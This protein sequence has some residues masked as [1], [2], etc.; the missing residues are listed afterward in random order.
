MLNIMN[1]TTGFEDYLFDVLLTTSKN[2]PSLEQTLLDCQP[3]QVYKP[4]TISAYSNYA[5][6]LAAYI[7]EQIIGQD[8]YE[9]LMES[10]FLP[11]N[12]NRTSAHPLLSDKLELLDTKAYGY[13]PQK[14]AGFTLGSWSYVPLYPAGSVNGTAE[15]LA[16]FAIALMPEAGQDSL[17]FNKRETLDEMLTQSHQMGPQLHGFAHGFMEW[18]GEYRGVGHGGNS[19]AFST[20]LNIVP[21]E[22]FGVIVLTNASNEMDISAGLTEALIGR[23][24]KSV[25][26]GVGDL[27]SAKEVEGTYI[28]ARRMHRGFL[29]L[30][31][32]LSLLKVKVL[33]PNKIQLSMAGQVSTLVQTSPYVFERVDADGAI[34]KYHFGTVYF[35]MSDGKVMRMSGDYLPLPS[36]R[37]E[38]WLAVSLLVVILSTLYFLVTPI[39]LLIG[40]W[41]KKRGGV[42]V[43]SGNGGLPKAITLLVLCGAAILANNALLLVRMIVNNY[44]SF[45]EVRIHILLNYPLAG[46]AFI[47]TILVASNLKSLKLSGRHKVFSLATIFMIVAFICT[48]INWQFFKVIA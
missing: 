40:K 20:Q 2:R 28:S 31:G 11:L 7:A 16:Y 12:M 35:E 10:I 17:L 38:S 30:Y 46:L 18:D 3:M 44:R 4:G 48:L 13:Y 19:A 36:G 39:V 43:A 15:D 33:E 14:K 26:I 47:L 23:R 45:S 6:A 29:E 5:V 8:F 34:F 41:R 42:D 25:A 24:D 21:E 22:R 9:Y 1:H 27:P 37:T 32:Y